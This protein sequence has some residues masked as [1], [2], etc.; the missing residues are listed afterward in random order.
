MRVLIYP[1]VKLSDVSIAA[2]PPDGLVA[3]G[4]VKKPTNQTNNRKKAGRLNVTVRHTLGGMHKK[5][6]DLT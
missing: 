2:P 4:D 5:D 6:I 3:N 1:R